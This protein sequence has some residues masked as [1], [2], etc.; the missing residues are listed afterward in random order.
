MKFFNWIISLILVLTVSKAN[1]QTER[2]NILLLIAD[3][4]SYPHA[5]FL[6]D[7]TVKTPRIDRVASE[8]ISFSNAFAAAP[9][10]TASRASILT[11]RYPH[12][13]E[14]GANL[15]ST[16]SV[17]FPN[18]VSL[19]SSAGYFTGLSGKGWGPGNFVDGG[20]ENNPAGKSFSDFREFL[21]Q[22]PKDKPFCFWFGSS[23]PHR[24]YN[25]SSRKGTS[26][27][28]NVPPFWP[29]NDSVKSD[30]LDY[31]MEVEAFDSQVDQV[32]SM[33]EAEG[34]AENTIVI[35][36]SDNGMPFP[37][38]KANLYDYGVQSLCL[39]VGQ[40]GSNNQTKFLNT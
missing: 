26:A 4:W 3:D 17:K 12:Q 27:Q 13:L 18:Y 31:Y 37:R 15:W 38:A 16:L 20:Y 25:T 28:I 2:P 30:I 1:A 39:S 34:L 36:T 21:S 32:L 24:P 19:L 5:S 14:E 11:G 9:S 33:L 10:C 6:G 22:K 40:R 7:N 23:N 29:S 35:I 8:G